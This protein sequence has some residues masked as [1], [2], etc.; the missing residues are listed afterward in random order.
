VI[1]QCNSAGRLRLEAA[2]AMLAGVASIPASSGQVVRYRL[3]R[4]GT[5]S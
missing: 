4:G 3:D 5:G 2:F 1:A